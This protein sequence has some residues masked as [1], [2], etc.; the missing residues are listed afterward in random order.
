MFK[1]I[2]DCAANLLIFKRLILV[3]SLRVFATSPVRPGVITRLKKD[4]PWSDYL[5]KRPYPSSI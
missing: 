4:Y 2:E 5:E 3:L 1:E